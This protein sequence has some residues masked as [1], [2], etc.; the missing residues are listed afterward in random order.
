MKKLILFATLAALI[1]APMSAMAMSHEKHEGMD[2]GKMEGM[3]HGKMEG[4]DHSKMDHDSMMMQG[5]MMM[6]GSESVDGVKASAHLKDVSEAMGKMGMET[7]H[8]LMIRFVNESNSAE[9]EKGT[10]AVKVTGPD[11]KEGAPVK[12]MGM[13]G[14][15]GADLALKQKGMYH[16]QIGTRLEDGEKRQYEFKTEIK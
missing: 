3:D 15:F 8:H 2:H 14:H 6:L 1:A 12:L 11:G 10:V 16:F 5:G 13:Q 7:T 4:M 9:L